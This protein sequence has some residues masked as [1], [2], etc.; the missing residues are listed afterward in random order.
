L[1]FDGSGKSSTGLL[2]WRVYD[3]GASPNFAPV[4]EA[5]VD[6]VV[7]FKGKTYLS[8]EVK[9]DGRQQSKLMVRWSKE[10][11]PGE[12]R[13]EDGQSQDTKAEFRRWVT[14]S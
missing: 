3:S 12:V 9:D 13:F 2:E 6:R 4:V 10:S 11:G 7:V 5:G 8:A 14:T 1:E